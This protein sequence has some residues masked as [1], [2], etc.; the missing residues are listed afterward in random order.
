MDQRDRLIADVAQMIDVNVDYRANGTVGIMTRSGIGI[1]DTGGAAVFSF[2]GAGQVS[3]T[4]L[5]DPDP[6]KSGVGALTL[7]SP[8]GLKANLV[9]EKILQS[10]RLKALVDLRDDTLV[11]AQGQLD[12]IAAALAQSLSTTETS[13]TPASAGAAS[14]FAV[15]IAGVRPGNDIV[16][17]YTSGGQSRSV[18]VVRVEDG[19]QLPMDYTDANGARVIGLSFAGGAGAVAGALNTLLGPGLAFANPS[20]SQLR[21][22]DDGA[23]NT[24]DVSSVTARTTVAGTQGNGLALSLFVDSG[25]ADFT[26]AIAG[27][28]QRRGFASRITVNSDIRIDN[29]LLVQYASG[30]S[31]GD[32]SR[33]EYLRD[34]LGTARFV[35]QS[36]A[37]AIDGNFRLSGTAG[38]MVSQ[39]LNY[40]GNSAAA[41]KS[42]KESRD[43]T[44]EAITQRLDEEYGVDV[45]EEMARLMELQNAFAANA[46]IVSAV[47][48]LINALLEI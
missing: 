36:S 11:R 48:D 3:A 9:T 6:A 18:R 23:S 8:S 17:N 7:T 16:L 21:V 13:G 29:R 47:Q 1:L 33:A 22:L 35:S 38:D 24:T 19:S 27:D 41:A 31:L 40:Q 12:D 30:G 32:A 43:L 25:N 5:F 34:R 14:G 42:N 28:P 4:S 26:D 44:M 10:G 15:D 45:D 39:A 20:G 2:E 46:R 37:N